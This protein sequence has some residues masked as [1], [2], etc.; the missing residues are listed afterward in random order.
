M[1]SPVPDIYSAYAGEIYDNFFGMEP[2]SA[3]EFILFIAKIFNISLL[4]SKI[5]DLGCG[6]GRILI[7]LLEKGLNIVGCEPSKTMRETLQAKLNKKIISTAIY[8][9]YAHQITPIGTF[10]I[11]L[12]IDNVFQH[13]LTQKEQVEALKVLYSS[14]N[15]SGLVIFDFA[16]YFNLIGKFQRVDFRKTSLSNKNTVWLTSVYKIDRIN[17]MFIQ[18][19]YIVIPETGQ[20]FQTDLIFAII[21]G[22]EFKQLLFDVGFRFVKIYSDF[23]SRKEATTHAKRLIIVAQK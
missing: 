1:S 10:D 21:A 7:P 18:Q 8:E 19:D 5:L 3:I 20:T 13:Y 12:L 22:G 2:G 17:A 9:Y 15:V 11:I 6:T 23:A 14:L 16:N 4:E